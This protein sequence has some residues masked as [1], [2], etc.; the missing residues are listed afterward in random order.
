M[1]HLQRVTIA[2]KQKEW[3]SPAVAKAAKMVEEAA[4]DPIDRA[5]LL[6]V[7]APH[8]SD[9]LNA[10]PVT[11][12]RLRLD[13]ESIQCSDWITTWFEDLRAPRVPVWCNC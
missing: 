1:L 7:A 8:A 11:S 4:R 6:A 12:C 10:L 13:D 3:D 9:W 5:R 2:K